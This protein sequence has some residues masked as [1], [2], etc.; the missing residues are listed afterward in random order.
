MAQP[1]A[2]Q[3]VFRVRTVTCFVTLETSDF[4]NQGSAAAVV[5]DKVAAAANFV[6][7]AETTLTA[8][9][10]TVQTVRIATNPFGEWLLDT[11]TDT[12]TTTA[13]KTAVTAKLELLDRLLSEH[14]I[15]YCALGP[16]VTVQQVKDWCVPILQTSGRFYCSAALQ[17][18]DVDVALQCAATILE[19]SRIADGL[20]NFR[21]CVAAAAVDCIPFFPVAKARSSINSRNQFA[22]GLEN[23]ALAF[24]LLSDCGSIRNV[25]TVFS[26]GMRDALTPLQL[27]CQDKLGIGD[28]EFVGIDTSLN[29][30]LDNGGSVAAAIEC[31]DE[32]ETFGGP[33]TLAAAATITETLQTLPGIQHCGYSGLML[34]VCEDQRLAELTSRS[35]N[36]AALVI[37]N[38]LSIS[39]VC[40]VGVDTVPIPGDCTEKQLASLLLDVA[41]MAHRWNKSLSCRVFP[42]AGKQAGDLTTFDSPH[43]VNSRILP[44][45]P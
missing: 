15:E 30:S 21:F 22:I 28:F 10:Y 36:S 2:Y 26:K 39:Q 41:G 12:S 14:Q 6:R 25:P 27:L 5:A 17:Q 3:D 33:G 11:D 16:A 31:L 42:V 13:T 7:L 1:H 23:G 8:A 44:L 34:P 18:N 19:L 20:G 24:K 43:M 4:F 45:S 37:A 38:L 9:G 29:P 32:V 40:G 35:T